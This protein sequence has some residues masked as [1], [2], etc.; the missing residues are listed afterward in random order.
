MNSLCVSKQPSPE[1]K[2][3]WKA[4]ALTE[5]LG[6]VSRHPVLRRQRADEQEQAQPVIHHIHDCGASDTTAMRS[7]QTTLLS[8]VIK[9]VG[10]GNV[11]GSSW[12]ERTR[13]S[14]CHLQICFKSRRQETLPSLVCVETSF[15]AA[16]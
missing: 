1:N 5:E 9:F 10:A 13:I 7:T 11:N 4:A 8:V 2:P 3:R 12:C 14:K 16:L 15:T 6:S